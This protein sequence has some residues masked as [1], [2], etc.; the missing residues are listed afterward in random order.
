MGGFHVA[1]QPFGVYQALD[2]LCNQQTSEMNII[3]AT[4]RFR[5]FIEGGK[6]DDSIRLGV[7]TRLV[8][9]LEIIAHES[10]QV[11]ASAHIIVR[12]ADWR[13]AWTNCFLL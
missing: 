4:R 7:V 3:N 2:W 5:K 11:R 8:E 1:T 9:C 13:C 12:L 10:R 6:A